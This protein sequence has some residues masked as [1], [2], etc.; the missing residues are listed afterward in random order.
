MVAEGKAEYTTPSKKRTSIKNEY[1]NR[2]KW[3]FF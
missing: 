3:R 2:K 1:R